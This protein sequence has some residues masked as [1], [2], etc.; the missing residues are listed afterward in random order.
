M[1]RIVTDE[2]RWECECGYGEPAVK[3]DS[4]ATVRRM[5]VHVRDA[6][7][8]R[9]LDEMLREWV[10][11]RAEELRHEGKTMR[12]PFTGREHWMGDPPEPL[13]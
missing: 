7:G 11:E 12:D 3:G 5:V 13:K 4:M 2:E 10:H 1:R 8:E 6:H 9:A